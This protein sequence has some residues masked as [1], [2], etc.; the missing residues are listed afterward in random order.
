MNEARLKNTAIKNKI[1]ILEEVSY[2]LKE[3][4]SIRKTANHFE[5]DF[6]TIQKDLTIYLKILTDSDPKLIETY[7]AVQNQIQKN[8]NVEIWFDEFTLYKLVYDILNGVSK[9]ELR[10]RAAEYLN[11]RHKR[12]ENDI[13]LKNVITVSMD[14]LDKNIERFK[15]LEPDTYLEIK[16]IWNQKQD[17][18]PEKI[19]IPDEILNEMRMEYH[20][21]HSMRKLVNRFHYSRQVIER[22]L[23]EKM[24]EFYQEIK[25]E[26]P[27]S[28]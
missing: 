3:N 1:R 25:G 26:H 22:E 28:K 21:T 4:T 19:S 20:R 13:H 10:I 23:N 15:E 17:T 12:L 7:E 16:K 24:P 14:T 18:K 11:D 27:K 6:K 9:R 8:K 5:R 2:F